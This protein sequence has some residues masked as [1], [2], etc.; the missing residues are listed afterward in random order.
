V[1]VGSIALRWWYRVIGMAAVKTK[2]EEFRS[3]RVKDDA[4]RR[5]GR[6]IGS[7][8]RFHMVFRGG[9]GTGKTHMGRLVGTAVSSPILCFARSHLNWEMPVCHPCSCPNH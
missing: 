1:W 9:P 6:D 5:L 8:D 4:R 3:G 7:D 2:V